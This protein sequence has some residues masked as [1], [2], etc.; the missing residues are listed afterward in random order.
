M[1][2]REGAHPPPRTL[3]PERPPRAPSSF[4]VQHLP[5]SLSAHPSSKQPGSTR[6]G[7]TSAVDQWLPQTGPRP[8]TTHRAR[9]ATPAAPVARAPRATNTWRGRRNRNPRVSE[10]ARGQRLSARLVPGSNR[11]QREFRTRPARWPRPRPPRPLGALWVPPRSARWEGPGSS[12]SRSYHL[13][14]CHP[15]FSSTS[16]GRDTCGEDHPRPPV[17]RC[18]AR[19]RQGPARERKRS[20]PREGSGM[21]AGPCPP[22]S[23][24]APYPT[25]GESLGPSCPEAS[26]SWGTAAG[27][28]DSSAQSRLRPQNRPIR[29]AGAPPA[30]PHVPSGHAGAGGRPARD[31]A[32]GESSARTSGTFGRLFLPFPRG[33][34]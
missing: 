30:A 19:A 4:D 2:R 29:T 17:W 26:R 10:D 28:S 15:L 21:G 23:A 11:E 16:D 32:E 13:R 1:G 25:W 3:L 34:T 5:D 24:H 18:P 33:Y 6:T 22:G 8:R 20:W 12:L 27:G 9:A 7:V 14:N 31:P